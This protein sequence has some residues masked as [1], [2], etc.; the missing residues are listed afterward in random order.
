MVDLVKKG[1][2]KHFFFIG[3]CDGAETE[4]TYFRD[5]AQATP[6]DSVILT[7]GYVCKLICA[8]KAESYM[9]RAELM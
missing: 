9:Y 6:K 7:A 4:R 8:Q 5:L 3:G 1:E 2:I